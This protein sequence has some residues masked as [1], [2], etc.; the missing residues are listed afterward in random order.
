MLAGLSL[1]FVGLIG[2][3]LLRGLYGPAAVILP[4]RPGYYGLLV[5]LRRVHPNFVAAVQQH[6]HARWA[7]GLRVD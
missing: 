6:Q 3:V 7:A 1:V 5:E 4:Q 2:I